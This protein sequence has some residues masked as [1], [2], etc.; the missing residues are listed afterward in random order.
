VGL[1]EGG[2]VTHG[3]S[4][5]VAWFNDHHTHAQLMEVFDRLDGTPLGGRVSPVDLAQG[6][7][8]VPTGRIRPA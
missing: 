4:S 5:A 8:G 2:V 3:S 7:G 1:F 6:D